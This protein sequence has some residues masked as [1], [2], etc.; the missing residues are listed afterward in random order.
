M[1]RSTRFRRPPG[2]RA[3]WPRIAA[4]GRKPVPITELHGFYAESAT[5]VR[6][7]PHGSSFRMRTTD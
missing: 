4:C 1:Q 7:L 6:E 2:T 3:A 5:Q